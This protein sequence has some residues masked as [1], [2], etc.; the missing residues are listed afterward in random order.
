MATHI[1]KAYSYRRNGKLV[2]VPAKRIRT[3]S[4]SRKPVTRTTRTRS[5]TRRTRS[6][7]RSRASRGAKGKITKNFYCSAT[8]VRYR[9]YESEKGV[10]FYKKGNRTV[11]PSQSAL[12]HGLC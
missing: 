7:S 8:G 5:R 4:R 10:L 6:R 3:R 1:R 12:L 9:L 11:R 2:R